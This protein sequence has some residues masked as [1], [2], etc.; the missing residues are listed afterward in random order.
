MSATAKMI[1]INVSHIGGPWDGMDEKRSIRE[2][3]NTATIA[4]GIVRGYGADE[5]QSKPYL[6]HRYELEAVEGRWLLQYKGY[7]PSD[8][9]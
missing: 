4:Q 8:T 3:Q 1:T 5:A 7:E 2:G 9:P 6:L